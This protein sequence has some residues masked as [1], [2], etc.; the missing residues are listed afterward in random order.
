MAPSHDTKTF[1][2]T[3][4]NTQKSCLSGLTNFVKLFYLKRFYAIDTGVLIRE[5][6]A[7]A[8]PAHR[9]P[10]ARESNGQETGD[11]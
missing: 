3:G 1:L 7:K 10:M 4:V 2:V 5:F 6:A 11:E 8:H 9:G